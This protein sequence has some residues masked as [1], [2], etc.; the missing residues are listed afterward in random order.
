MLPEF[1][2]R[3]K[4]YNYFSTCVLFFFYSFMETVSEYQHDVKMWQFLG[5]S[6]HDTSTT[7]PFLPLAVTS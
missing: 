6:G 1:V 4:T 3:D 7:P 5:Q 2:V